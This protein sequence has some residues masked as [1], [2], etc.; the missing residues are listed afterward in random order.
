MLGVFFLKIISILSTT[1][2]IRNDIALSTTAP[3]TATHRH[4]T[5]TNPDHDASTNANGTRQGRRGHGRCGARYADGMF[6]I[7]FIFIILIT[8]KC[9]QKITTPKPTK[10]AQTMKHV[11]SFG[12]E[13][14]FFIFLFLFLMI[15][16]NYLQKTMT[17]HDMRRPQPRHCNDDRA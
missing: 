14:S 11:T 15:I 5:G 3:R 7:Y 10:G 4:N 1:T 8:Y 6:I 9:L 16:Y 2:V 12:P 13:V 17:N